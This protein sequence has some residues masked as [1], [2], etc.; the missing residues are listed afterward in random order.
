MART[1][2]RNGYQENCVDVVSLFAIPKPFEGR[3]AEIQLNAI[4][5]W[6]ALGPRCEIFLFGAER[7]TAEVAARFGLRHLPDVACNE[8]G[9]PLLNSIFTQAQHAAT[10]DILCYVN[11]DI[12]LMEDLLEAMRRVVRERWPA[13]VI[14]RR[15]DLGVGGT[16]EFD[17]IGSTARLRRLV[18]ARGRLHAPYA[19]D[20]FLFPRGLW[21]DIPPFAIGRTLW[22]NWFIWRA[23][24]LGVPIIDASEAIMAVHQEHDYSH[25]RGGSVAAWQGP[26][27]ARN[28]QL[29]G[30]LD[31]IYDLR[32]ATWILTP[33]SLRRA[34]G[35]RYVLRRLTHTRPVRP[36]VRP[37][38]K[39]KR[40]TQETYRRGANP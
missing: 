1:P 28:L 15:W 17:G 25:L 30:G 8:H 14:G 20:Y 10:H 35:L 23:S 24:M 3:I 13:V 39:L 32:D 36:L 12:L 33:T 22:D 37:L 6:I 34:R 38:R 27:A 16:W 29:L 40:I 4:R 5:S 9:T 7:G 18:Q 19:M 21:Q 2:R 26:E 31:H 11:A